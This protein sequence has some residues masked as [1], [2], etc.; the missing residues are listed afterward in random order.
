MLPRVSMY[1]D[2]LTGYPYATVTGERAVINEFNQQ[3]QH[4]QIG[5]IYGLKYWIRMGKDPV[6]DWQN[7]LAKREMSEI[8]AIVSEFGIELYGEEV[9]PVHSYLRRLRGDTES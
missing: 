9:M 4:R 6:S 3:T 8:L 1:F 5:Q 2:D 7:H